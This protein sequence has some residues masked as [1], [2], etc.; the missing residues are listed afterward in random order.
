[1]AVPASALIRN[2]AVVCPDQIELTGI[3]PSVTTASF[4]QSGSRVSGSWSI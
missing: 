4:P 1:M 2:P 3:Q